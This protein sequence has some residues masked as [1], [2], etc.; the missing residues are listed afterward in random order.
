MRI[1][2]YFFGVLS[3]FVT[4]K[5][6]TNDLWVFFDIPSLLVVGSI[7]VSLMAFK[8]GK[9]AF[10]FWNLEES[11]RIEV[12][13]WSGKV[14]LHSGALGTLLGL[15]T[16]GAVGTVNVTVLPPALAV[17]FTTMLYSYVAYLFLFA[18]F[19]TKDLKAFDDNKGPIKTED[20][21]AA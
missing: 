8:F 1:F 10:Y 18:P 20:K 5:M 11:E 9:K 16:I 17:C 12:A 6:C 21:L 3:L 14:C 15:I 13:K 7:T 2:A 4:L 19:M